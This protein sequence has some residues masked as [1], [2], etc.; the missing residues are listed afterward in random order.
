MSFEKQNQAK[1]NSKSDPYNVVVGARAVAAAVLAKA[2]PKRDAFANRLYWV[3]LWA[4]RG[5]DKLSTPAL[6]HLLID[7]ENKN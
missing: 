4:Q 6:I 1:I 3:Q 2:D 7:F 5:P